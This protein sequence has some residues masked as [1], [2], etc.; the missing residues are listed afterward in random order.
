MKR[1]A[2][3]AVAQSEVHDLHA[4][5]PFDILEIQPVKPRGWDAGK[6]LSAKSNAAL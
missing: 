4:V 1:A 3:E 5:D 2:L 6:V